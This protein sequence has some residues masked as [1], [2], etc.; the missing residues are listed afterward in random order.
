MLTEKTP[1]SLL[2]KLQ[3]GVDS[4]A[5]ERFV[6]LY[7]PLLYSWAGRAGL[8]AA[9]AD[10]LVQEVF[11]LLLE[12]LPAFQYDPRRS[13]RGWLKQVLLNK[14]RTRC[15]KRNAIVSGGADEL[16]EPE[17][18]ESDRFWEE[19]YRQ[20]LVQRSLELIQEQFQPS[21]WKAFWGIVVEEK[22]VAQVSAELGM[23]AN[24]AYGAKF[25]VL[26]YLR[27]ELEGLLH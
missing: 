2:R 9:D 15:R 5:W 21:T 24:A 27:Q 11:A 12:K 14:F 13:F 20:Y 25:R 22:A 18:N 4:S 23:S 16:P 17:I 26:T 1:K 10:D 19:E 3:I 8:S 6:E 7:T